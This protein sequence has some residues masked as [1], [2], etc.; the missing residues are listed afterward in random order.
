MGCRRRV[1]L[2]AWGRLRQGKHTRLSKT[3]HSLRHA[4]VTN[5]IRHKV[6]PTEIMT[7]T[8]HKSLD[9]ILDYAHEVDRESDPA[10]GCVDYRSGK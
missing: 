3:T 10:E 9:T 6:P 2:S 4:L 1:S 7:V 5:L 8:R